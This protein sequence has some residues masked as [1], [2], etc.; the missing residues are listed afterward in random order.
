MDAIVD[1]S[2]VVN[3]T[4]MSL[5]DLGYE[6][7]GLDDGWQACGTGI[8]GSFHD[9]AGRPLIDTDKFPD[10]G[11]MVAKA[12]KLGL[13]AGWY[14]NNCICN[15]RSFTGAFIETALQGSVA[16]LHALQF[17]GVK[18]D[19]CSQFNNLTRWNELINASGR[20][21]LVENCACHVVT[22]IV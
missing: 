10:M 1:R 2:R 17:D 22:S 6:F 20:P 12:H 3:G 8:N 16:A 9:A 14:M 4:P 11:A 5:H 18:L 19:S 13:K 21:T 15:E 7:V